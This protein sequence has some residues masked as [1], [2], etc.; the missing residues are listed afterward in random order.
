MSDAVATGSRLDPEDR[1]NLSCRHYHL[2]L[3]EGLLVL[4]KGKQIG[5]NV[6]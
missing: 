4:T 2:R 1:G 5:K 6:V 3:C